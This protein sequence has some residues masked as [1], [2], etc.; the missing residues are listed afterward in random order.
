MGPA[1]S[2]EPTSEAI[3][4]GARRLAP[5]IGA[6]LCASVRLYAAFALGSNKSPSGTFS[7]ANGGASLKS[8]LFQLGTF[9]SFVVLNLRSR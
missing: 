7:S 2:S 4:R 6:R 3:A 8:S 1:S 5:G 9:G